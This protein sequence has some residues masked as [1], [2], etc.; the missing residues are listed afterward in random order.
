MTL[1]LTL[2]TIS[3]A[4]AD[5]PVQYIEFIEPLQ[6]EGELVKPSIKLVTQRQPAHFERG[7]LIK[8]MII[9]SQFRNYK[10]IPGEE[11]PT[12]EELGLFEK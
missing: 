2:L 6:I 4:S 1:L 3:S 10:P 11:L 12:F 5:Q 8:S 7:S 9:D